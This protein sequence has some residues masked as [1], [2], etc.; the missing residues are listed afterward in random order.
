MGTFWEMVLFN[1]KKILIMRAI[2][3]IILCLF[4]LTTFSQEIEIE[5]DSVGFYSWLD[6]EKPINDK[7]LYIYGNVKLI[8]N[9]NDIIKLPKCFDLLPHFEDTL[10]NDIQWEFNNIDIHSEPIFC[11]YLG[12][13]DRKPILFPGKSIGTNFKEYRLILFN[14]E[15]ENEYYFYYELYTPWENV[16][17]KQL[18]I[19]GI[20]SNKVKFR[21]E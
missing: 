10:G 2:L 11:F 21:Y 4:F 16:L 9:T 7:H 19:K 3:I 17:E 13:F 6:F 20:F 8:N 5:I 15:L 1:S 14:L 12:F 18:G